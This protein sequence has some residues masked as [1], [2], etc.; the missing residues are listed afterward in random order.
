MKKRLA[1]WLA[2][3]IITIVAGLSLA[4]TNEVTKDVISQQ[5]DQA[6]VEAR[7]AVLP[8]AQT[9]EE[10]PQASL[11]GG[12]AGQVT[13]VFAGMSDAAVVG[14]VGKT[15]VSGYGGPIEIIAGVLPDGTISG[16]SVGGA[17]FAETP[18][19]GAK[20]RDA[21]FIDGVT[22]K[23]APLKV[24]KAG[25]EKGDDTVDAISAATITSRS[26]TAG[27]NRIAAEIDSYLNPDTGA[28][29][30]AEGTTYTA[31]EEGYKSPV[32][33][34]VTVKDDGTIS[35]LLVGDDQFNETDGLGS[36]ARDKAFTDQ[37]V[38]KS[39][40]V[41]IGDI[42]AL[43]G[44]TVTTN[45]VLA[46]INRAYDEKNV[47]VL[48]PPAP[49]GTTYT[50]VAEG[51]KGPVAVFVTVKD[52]GT[53][54]HLAVG[55]D[56][57]AETDGL[58]SPARDKAFTGQFVGKTIPVAIG[59]IDALS[60]ATVTTNAVLTAINQ[61][62][63]DKTIA[64]GGLPAP[65]AAATAAPAAPEVEVPAGA[66]TAAFE[67]YHS[68]VAVAV[69][70]DENGAIDFLKI[71][72][73]RFSETEGL[74]DKV[75]APEF[76]AQFIGKTPPLAIADIDTIA[77]ATWTVKAVLDGINEAA[78]KAASGVTVVP[79]TEAPAAEEDAVPENAITAAF[80]GYHSMVAVAVTFDDNG[81]IDFLKIGD[82]RFSE[83]EGLGDKVLAPEFAAQFIGKTPPIAIADID[84][85]A[86]AT[87]TVKAVL[88]GINEAATKAGSA[89]EATPEPTAA[90]AAEVEVP[91]NAI[92][93]AFEGYHSMV[94]VAVTFDENGAIDF[95][96]IGDGRFSETE[97]LG[98]KVLAPEFAEQ[99]IG[100]TPPLA[101]EDIDTIAGATWTVKAVLDGINEAATKAGK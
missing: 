59:D 61:A 40:P 35:Q 5:A 21:A 78:G 77:G 67:G 4:M 99:F 2:L 64:E 44:A 54:T 15:V 85:I 56:K 20:V 22:G 50:A 91:E 32:T 25:E 37:F 69:T 41:A 51:Y 39:L 26:V 86:G 100:K 81:A 95:L 96:K 90:P 6:E 18:G 16:V 17:N 52:D 10:V 34:F 82:A 65:T 101:V 68:M 74:G 70:F 14:H 46:A 30:V 92:T 62:Y 89:A 43:S 75:L 8:E 28:G 60:G 33:V 79:V 47:I 73:A 53:I 48:G 55:D 87:W 57:F 36:P 49:E 88:D 24:V 94:A 58:G 23:K 29:A 80:E 45:A 27:I 7:A 12:E 11:P 71:G 93:A 84:T 31:T 19:L 1:A 76:A 83:T 38:G 97:G 9:F 66:Y 72:D 13:N 98:D 3:G 63:A 42:D